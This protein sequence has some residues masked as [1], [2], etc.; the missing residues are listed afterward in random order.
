MIQDQVKSKNWLLSTHN[1][2]AYLEWIPVVTSGHSQSSLLTWHKTFCRC[3]NIQVKV[4]YLIRRF[5][6]W[7]PCSRC[8]D[9]LTAAC[10][11]QEK[12]NA[13]D[14][15]KSLRTQDWHPIPIHLSVSVFSSLSYPL[16]PLLIQLTIMQEVWPSWKQVWEHVKQ[17][18]GGVPTRGGA[19]DVFVV[20]LPLWLLQA[21]L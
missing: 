19:E 11:Q 7:F 15:L 8:S 9:F 5:A 2:F 3:R 4:F 1:G 16:F 6:S 14:S 21:S 12:S 10:N 20:P 17:G 13:T 18:R